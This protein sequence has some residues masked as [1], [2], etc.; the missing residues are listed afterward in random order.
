MGLIMDSAGVVNITSIASGK[1]TN[2]YVKEG[3]RIQTGD[4][5]AHIE[6]PEQVAD[7]Q[8][9]QYEIWLASSERDVINQV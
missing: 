5:I 4:L 3:D 7:T 2:I 6:Q 1:I 8:I 9:S